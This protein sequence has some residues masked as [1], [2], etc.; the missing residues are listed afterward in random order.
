[1]FR[2]F[3]CPSSKARDYNFVIAAYGVW[4]LGCWWSAVRSRAAGYMSGVYE[5][6]KHFDQIIIAIKRSVASSWFSS[7][8]FL[9]KIRDIRF[10]G[11]RKSCSVSK[12]LDT[13]MEDTWFECRPE[14]LLFWLRLSDVFFSASRQKLRC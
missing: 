2:A 6:P 10:F 5:C 14:C 8:R 11:H 9:P 4:C 3:I 13:C 7:L 1:M 12:F